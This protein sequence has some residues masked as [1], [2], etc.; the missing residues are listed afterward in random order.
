MI[1]QTESVICSLKNCPCFNLYKK[2]TVKYPIKHLFDSTLK[3][4]VA[5]K[6][7]ATS[8]THT[9]SVIHV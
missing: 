7:T 9:M 4:Q 5:F 8:N 2:I 6:M 3:G 1:V